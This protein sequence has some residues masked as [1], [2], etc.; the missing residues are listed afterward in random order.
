MSITHYHHDGNLKLSS[1]ETQVSKA[2]QIPSTFGIGQNNTVDL[3]EHCMLTE[4]RNRMYVAV[5]MRGTCNRTRVQWQDIISRRR[6]AYKRNNYFPISVTMPTLRK[7]KLQLA[8]GIE[9]RHAARSQQQIP[10]RHIVLCYC[11]TDCGM[12]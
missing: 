12:L 10:D 6:G 7:R 5:T 3:H 8:I 4:E 2:N 9:L 11:N 1:K